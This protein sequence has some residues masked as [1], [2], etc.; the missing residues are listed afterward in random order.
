MEVF[1]SLMKSTPLKTVFLKGSM[2]SCKAIQLESKE[3]QAGSLSTLSKDSA[4]L[5]P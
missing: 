4:S 2:N 1:C 5:P 3:A